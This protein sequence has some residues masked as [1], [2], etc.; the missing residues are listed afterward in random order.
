[1]KNDGVMVQTLVKRDDPAKVRE[2]VN[3]LV[4]QVEVQGRAL[5]FYQF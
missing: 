4:K 1:M 2:R 5:K 3:F